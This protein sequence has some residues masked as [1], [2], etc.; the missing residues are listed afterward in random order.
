MLETGRYCVKRDSV[1][2]LMAATLEWDDR[3]KH[4]RVNFFLDGIPQDIDLEI[5]ELAVGE[6]VAAHWQAIKTAGSSYVFDSLL[7]KGALASPWLIFSR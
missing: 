7:L 3:Q 5:L 2:E 1:K 6:I 4:L